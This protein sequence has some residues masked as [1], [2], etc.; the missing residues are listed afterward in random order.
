LHKQQSPG[1]GSL[2]SKDFK[3][4]VVTNLKLQLNEESCEIFYNQAAYRKWKGFR[5][6]GVD[7]S[8]LQLPNH[9]SIVDMFGQHGF[10][11]NSD[12]F[13]STAVNR[14]LIFIMNAGILK[15]PI[16]LSRHVWM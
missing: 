9:E 7:G 1:V 6:L 12:A 16:N 2:P 13:K 15:R 10:G 3:E 11:P 14:S 4:N 5:V 8:T